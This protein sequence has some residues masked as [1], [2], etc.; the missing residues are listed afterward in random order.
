[1]KQIR[2]WGW[3]I[4]ASLLLAACGG[5][6]PEY[7]AAV[8]RPGRRQLRAVSRAVVSF[9]DSL[10]DVGTYAP[11]TS[12]TGDGQ[13]PFFG[14]KFTTNSVARQRSGSRT[15]PP[16]SGC[17]HAGRGRLQRPSVKCPAA[18][19]PALATTCTGYGQG[20]ARVTDP[21]GIGHNPDGTRRAD[22]AD[23]DADREP[24]GALRQLQRQRPGLR[25]TPA[26]T[27]CSCSSATFA[28]E[29]GADPGRCGRRQDH[30]RPGQCAAVPGPD[31]GAGGDEA[32]GAGADRLRAR[33]EILGQ[34]RQ[35]TSR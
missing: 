25:R 34:G 24:P 3:A 2:R 21:N 20:G 11:A 5:C 15:S 9:G 10:S 17:R 7:R 19:N 31:R 28:R 1:M 27:T 32:G 16:R 14:G 22:R 33:D 23:R 13:P 26:T 6:D 12:I 18:A 4:V 35:A 8:R 29:R 30:G